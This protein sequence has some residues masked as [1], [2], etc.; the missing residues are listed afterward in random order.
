M[1]RT[2][3]NLPDPVVPKLEKVDW[4]VITEENYKEVFDAL[5]KAK[6][7][8]VLFGLTDDGYEVLAVNLAKVRKYLVLHKD[9]LA[10]YRDY[11][12]KKKAEEASEK[13]K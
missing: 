12:E 8:V 4:I 7:D 1:E 6:K 11:Y 13:K 9:V 2:P 3:L 5:R 10:K